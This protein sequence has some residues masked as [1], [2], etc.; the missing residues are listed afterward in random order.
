MNEKCQRKCLGCPQVDGN[1]MN[2]KELKD[3]QNDIWEES[4]DE[5]LDVE[6]APNLFA[7]LEQQGL[8]VAFPGRGQIVESPEEMAQAIRME[9]TTDLKE[10]T[11]RRK[12]LSLALVALTKH[13]AGPVKMRA[14]RGDRTVTVSVCMSP[15][16]PD[17]SSFEEVYVDRQSN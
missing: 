15:Q 3:E 16:A 8:K 11:E 7:S 1:L 17:D 10:I 2:D 4:F 9:L 12:E 13:C 6:K 14:R 5:D